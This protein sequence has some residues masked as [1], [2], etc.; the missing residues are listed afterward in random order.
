MFCETVYESPKV[1]YQVVEFRTSENKLKLKRIFDQNGILLDRDKNPT[2]NEELVDAE[3]VTSTYDFF[4]PVREETF[5]K[6]MRKMSHV[7]ILK[8]QFEMVDGTATC[9]PFMVEPSHLSLNDYDIIFDAT[10]RSVTDIRNKQLGS[11]SFSG[12]E[13]GMDQIVAATQPMH[14]F[15]NKIGGDIL[16]V[17]HCHLN[18]M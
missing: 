9:T 16:N 15:T 3:F 6:D 8:Y 13:M 10:S 17:V 12:L 18:D 2:A 11:V 5:K 7:L 1:V 4:D 14:L